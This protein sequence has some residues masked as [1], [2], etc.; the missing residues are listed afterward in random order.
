MPLLVQ[1][2]FRAFERWPPPNNGDAFDIF[3]GVGMNGEAVPQRVND[4]VSRTLRGTRWS[5]GVTRWLD[6]R[7]WTFPRVRP[8]VAVPGTMCMGGYLPASIVLTGRTVTFNRAQSSIEISGYN[9][10]LDPDI[11]VGDW[12]NIQI[13]GVASPNER[14]VC[15]RGYDDSRI[16]FYRDSQIFQIFSNEVLPSVTVRLTKV[17]EGTSYPNAELTEDI[18]RF[19]YRYRNVAGPYSPMAW[20]GNG[21]HHNIP[22]QPYTHGGASLWDLFS[23]EI[24]IRSIVNPAEPTVPLGHE[25]LHCI[26]VEGQDRIF[27]GQAVRQSPQHPWQV[28]STDNVAPMSARAGLFGDIGTSPSPYNNFAGGQPRAMFSSDA[29]SKLPASGFVLVSFTPTRV[30]ANGGGGT[31]TLNFT[32]AGFTSGT[33]QLARVVCESPAHAYHNRVIAWWGP[34]QPNAGAGVL[35]LISGA[36]ENALM[37]SSTPVSCRLERYVSAGQQGPWRVGGADIVIDRNA[38]TIT[39][40]GMPLVSCVAF[41]LATGMDLMPSAFF[42]LFGHNMIR[43]ICP[44][45][46][47]DG[48]FVRPVGIGDLNTAGQPQT[49]FFDRDDLDGPSVVSMSGVAVSLDQVEF[50]PFRMMRYRRGDGRMFYIQLPFPAAQTECLAIG[51]QL[52]PGKPLA[53]KRYFT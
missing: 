3:N 20:G 31:G 15:V 12:F 13:D 26:G 16:Y 33:F 52:Y 30:T 25:L 2:K 19:W 37:T 22:A 17:T 14:S 10:R 38:G 39:R 4:P 48:R 24:G 42:S 32:Q 45:H 27:Q 1:P 28:S 11:I 50:H 7:E 44:G 40:I 18:Y 8:S 6:Y 5:D 34:T 47:N 46:A 49:I 29:A 36:C 9:P 53:T 51:V 35:E 21:G 23:P 43:L 41:P